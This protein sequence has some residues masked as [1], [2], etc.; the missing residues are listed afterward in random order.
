M[1]KKEQQIMGAISVAYS[2]PEVKKDKT[3]RED[4]F[5]AAKKLNTMT[6]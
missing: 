2:D 6:V 1:N 5:K 4:L 3:I